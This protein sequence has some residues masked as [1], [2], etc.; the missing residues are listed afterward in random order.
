[1]KV[2]NVRRRQTVHLLD[3]QL[4]EL[5][6]AHDLNVELD[7][8]LGRLLGDQLRRLDVRL[9][10][11]PHVKVER[12]LVPVLGARPVAVRLPAR[13]VEHLVRELDV[14]RVECSG[15]S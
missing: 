10:L 13:I 12:E 14:L 1:M 2:S 8:D 3:G 6:D 7:A 5:A 4:G 11:G 15:T 9:G